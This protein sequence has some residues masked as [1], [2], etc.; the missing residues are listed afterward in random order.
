MKASSLHRLVLLVQLTSLG[1][2]LGH[3]DDQVGHGAQP[4]VV[5]ADL[6]QLVDQ[7]VELHRPRIVELSQS[8]RP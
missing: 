7:A 6:D 4:L 8:C 3:L 1:R 5:H 2:L